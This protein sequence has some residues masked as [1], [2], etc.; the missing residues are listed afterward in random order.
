MTRIDSVEVAAPYRGL[1][2]LWQAQLAFER[3]LPGAAEASLLRA[4]DA[5]LPQDERSYVAGMCA[6]SSPQAVLQFQ[7]AVQH[8]PMHHR[9]RRMLV[10]MLISLARFDEALRE[11][12]TSRQLYALDTDF[13][14]LESLV[15][16]ARGETSVAADIL[17]GLHLTPDERSGWTELCESVAF[18]T[19][20][21]SPGWH[22]DTSQVDELVQRFVG[23]HRPLLAARGIHPPPRIGRAFQDF[24]SDLAKFKDE[25]TDPRLRDTICKIVQVHP[26]GSLFVLLGELQLMDKS[27]E[28][29]D[30]VDDALESF[31]QS[32]NYPAF[33]C[34]AHI[35]SRS[36]IIG[37]TLMKAVKFH[38]DWDANVTEFEAALR[39]IDPTTLRPDHPYVRTFAVG[40]VNLG[41]WDL[42]NIW[43]DR[44]SE[45]EYSD[46]DQRRACLR[47]IYWNRIVMELRQ[48]HWQNVLRNCDLLLGD[49]PTH[50]EA[51]KIRERA[52][53]ALRVLIESPEKT[54]V[55]GPSAERSLE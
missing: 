37:S 35:A 7:Q 25:P 52:I 36:G 12:Q 30:D 47:D 13:A 19:Q 10:T 23:R 20:A 22:Q 9:A 34:N 31:R 26:E 17:T 14:L 49:D 27:F 51:R 40:A 18:L 33:L 54:A 53:Q 32:L 11:I 21:M 3:Q 43:L 4:A 15:R 39:G 45:V 38:L 6:D 55:D 8:N 28:Q 5:Y 42:A 44:W 1:V 50:E 48:K 46:S 16:S 41:V 29:P 24:P 2:D